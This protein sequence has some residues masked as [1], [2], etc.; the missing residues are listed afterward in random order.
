LLQR[1]RAVQV[2]ERIGSPE[3]RQILEA[4]AKGAPG[5][6]ETREAQASLSRL[7]R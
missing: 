6:R 1:L 4:L 5:A 3:A 7:A 2:L